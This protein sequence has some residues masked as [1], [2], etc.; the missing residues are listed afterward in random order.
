M[1]AKVLLERSTKYLYHLQIGVTYS[2][3]LKNSQ[4]VIMTRTFEKQNVALFLKKNASPSNVIF[5]Q[6]WSFGRGPIL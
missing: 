6:V 2:H 5:R 1:F 4:N 3:L